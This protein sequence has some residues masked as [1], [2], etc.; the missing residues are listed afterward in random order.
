MSLRFN[1][2]AVLWALLIAVLSL[3]SDVGAAE[4]YGANFDKVVHT[5]LYCFF[6]TIMIVGFKKQKWYNLKVY[7]VWV[8]L[9]FSIFYGILME[10]IQSYIPSRGFAILDILYN[11]IGSLLGLGLFYLIYRKF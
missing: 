5:I 3:S 1:A 6:V 8:A 2:Y 7:A 9:S 4:N 11:S 10:V